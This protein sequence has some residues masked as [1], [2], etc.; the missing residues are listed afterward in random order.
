MVNDPDM[1][2]IGLAMVFIDQGKGRAAG[3]FRKSKMPSQGPD[4]SGFSGPHLA[5]QGYDAVIHQIGEQLEAPG[6]QL[7]FFG[8]DERSG[9]HV[10]GLQS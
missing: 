4:E 1:P 9:F 8:Y 2:G 5:G 6:F 7:G 3:F 10:K